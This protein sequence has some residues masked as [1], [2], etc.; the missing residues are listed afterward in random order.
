MDEEEEEE[1]GSILLEEE[2]DEHYRP[3][4]QGIQIYNLEIRE[5]ANFLGMELPEDNDLLY[6]AREGLMAPLPESW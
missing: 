1:Q 2:I 5:Y 4:N 6:I 3:T